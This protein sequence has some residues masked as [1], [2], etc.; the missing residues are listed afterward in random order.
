MQTKPTGISPLW[1][2]VLIGGW[3]LLTS[4]RWIDYG[5]YPKH[6]TGDQLL[7]AVASSLLTIGYVIVYRRRGWL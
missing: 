5:A 2:R 3:A 4:V 1:N 7:F 6:R